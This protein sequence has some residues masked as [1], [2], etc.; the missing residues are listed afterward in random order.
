VEI[1]FLSHI[2]NPVDSVKNKKFGK[3]SLDIAGFPP[4]FNLDAFD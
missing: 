1:Q 4:V 3:P 2:Q